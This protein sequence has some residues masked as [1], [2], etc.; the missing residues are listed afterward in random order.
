MSMANDTKEPKN[1]KVYTIKIV[2]NHDTNTVESV[3]ENIDTQFEYVSFN[4]KYIYI[5]DYYSDEDLKVL[6]DSMVIGE[7]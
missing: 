5:L 7:S 4:G 3:E 6:D 1:I 2:Y